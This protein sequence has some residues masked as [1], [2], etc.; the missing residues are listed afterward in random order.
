MRT[1]L[2]LLNFLKLELVWWSSEP[3]ETNLG[4]LK[5]LTHRC[6]S[7]SFPGKMSQFPGKELSGVLNNGVGAPAWPPHSLRLLSVA[8]HLCFW[9]IFSLSFLPSSPFSPFLSAPNWAYCLPSLRL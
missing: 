8:H 2:P 1:G 4:N 7:T 6:Y 5:G 9:F 3:S